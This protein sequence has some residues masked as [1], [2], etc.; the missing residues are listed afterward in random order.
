MRWCKA[1]IDDVRTV[2]RFLFL[3]EAVRGEWRWWEFVTIEERLVR[4]QWFK[5]WEPVRWVDEEVR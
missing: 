3:P 1:Q 2:R 4:R 5:Y